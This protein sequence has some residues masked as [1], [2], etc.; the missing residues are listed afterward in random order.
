MHLFELVLLCISVYLNIN[1]PNGPRTAV[2][3]EISSLPSL[4]VSSPKTCYCHGFLAYQSPT[5]DLWPELRAT[6]YLVFHQYEPLFPCPG[7]AI[8]N[9]TIWSLKGS[10][11]SEHVSRIR[12]RWGKLR[13]PYSLDISGCFPMRN[14]NKQQSR[15]NKHPRIE[16]S[17]TV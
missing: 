11:L 13:V 3:L 5:L 6:V 12:D 4:R 15:T 7:T 14:G 8:G 1:F 9:P 2:T 17:Q 10:G 16:L